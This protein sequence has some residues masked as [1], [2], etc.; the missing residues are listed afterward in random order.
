M[1]DGI[2]FGALKTPDY[3][4]DYA[5]AFAVGR[6]IGQVREMNAFNPTSGERMDPIARIAALAPE[7]RAAAMRRAELLTALGSGLASRPYAERRAI[8]AHMA[9]QLTALGLPAGALAGFDPNDANLSAALGQAR[10]L[11]QVLNPPPTVAASPDGPPTPSPEP[12]S[13]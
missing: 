2:D 7:G 6:A 13:E 5:N 8:I 9:P 12:P 11:Q 10:A 3:L 1:T 4:G